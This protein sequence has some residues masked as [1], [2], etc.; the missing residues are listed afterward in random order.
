MKKLLI[1]ALAFLSFLTV[2]FGFKENET[3]V[4]T[5]DI[6]V[7]VSDLERSFDFYTNIL[8]MEK[9]GTW[10]ATRELSANLGINSGK[11]FNIINLTLEC[12]GYVLKYKLNKTEGNEHKDKTKADTSENYGFEELGSIYLTINVKSVDP[13][14][15]RINDHNIK[16][17]MV[18]LPNGYRVVLLR[19]PD[20]VLIEIASF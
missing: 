15:E 11:A 16:Y 2:I 17:K 1:I 10:E 18:V 5:L 20:G 12:D 9:T 7:P 8:G 3:M 19:D 14:I 4:K 6:G 13:F